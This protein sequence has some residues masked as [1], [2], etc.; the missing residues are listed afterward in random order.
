MFMIM[1][2]DSGS[3]SVLLDLDD[4]GANEVYYYILCIVCTTLVLHYSLTVMRF[5]NNNAI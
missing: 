5:F 4:I 2:N 3:T 1:L